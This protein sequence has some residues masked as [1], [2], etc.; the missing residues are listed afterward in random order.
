MYISKDVTGF[1]CSLSSSEFFLFGKKRF[2]PCFFPQRNF[3]DSLETLLFCKWI[4]KWHVKKLK[5]KLCCKTRNKLMYCLCTGLCSRLLLLPL[6]SLSQ[7]LF[8][9]VL[10]KILTC[11]HTICL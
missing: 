8:L 2:Y 4:T 5:Q 6:S 3:S 7:D 9:F 11:T 1:L 10:G